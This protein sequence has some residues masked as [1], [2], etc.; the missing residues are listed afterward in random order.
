M[1]KLVNYSIHS[2]R[3]KNINPLFK[4]NYK[5]L[6]YANIRDL[7]K[8]SQKENILSINEQGYHKNNVN[9]FLLQSLAE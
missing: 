8:D 7:A 2:E 3:N 5:I 6:Y 4:E 9:N 1:H